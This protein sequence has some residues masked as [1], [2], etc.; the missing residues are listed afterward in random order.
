MMR[1][2]RKRLAAEIFVSRRD[3]DAAFASV[4]G[5]FGEPAWDMLLLL[6]LAD[7]EG[8]SA[9]H[10][11]LLFAAHVERDLAEPYIGWLVSKGLAAFGEVEGTIRLLEAG[12]N[13]M[14]RYLDRRVMRGPDKKFMH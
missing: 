7:S 5:G 8:G 6:Y 4:E 3:R 11:E 13:M 9:T 1:A 12:R 2:E 10:Q 14:D